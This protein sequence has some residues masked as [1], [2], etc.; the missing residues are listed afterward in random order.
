MQF[1][2]LISLTWNTAVT[3]PPGSL[4]CT[5]TSFSWYFC[6]HVIKTCI[7][8]HLL[9]VAFSFVGVRV[10]VPGSPWSFCHCFFLKDL[11]L[12]CRELVSKWVWD[13]RMAPLIRRVDLLSWFHCLFTSACYPPRSL[14]WDQS[15]F[16]HCG[17]EIL[18]WQVC[19]EYM[20]L[21]EFVA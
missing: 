8:F 14:T 20:P 15:C 5:T 12:E 17:Y 9:F 10:V 18:F 13:A 2:R 11:C 6:Q 4:I 19:E 1:T 21:Y 16:R 7:K 3:T